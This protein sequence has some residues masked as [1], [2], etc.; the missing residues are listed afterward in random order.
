M[1]G[2]PLNLNQTWP[3]GRRWYR[4]TNAL[5]KFRDG[6]P[7]IW[8]ANS[9]KFWTTCRDFRNRLRIS[10]ERNVAST[11]K[12][13][14]P[15]YNVSPKS[16]PTF[17]DL[18][19]R[20]GWDPFRHC[21]PPFGGHYVA[22]VKVATCLVVGVKR[23]LQLGTWLS[24]VWLPLMTRYWSSARLTV[25]GRNVCPK[26]IAAVANTFLMVASTDSL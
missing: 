4:F 17:R 19:P 20:N 6:P 25:A 12:N 5:Q 13:A 22:T 10:P 11:N 2:Q 15:I 3:V 8:C 23:L 26:R 16:W 24:G 14:M 21:D 18:W 1:K 7:Q 9:I